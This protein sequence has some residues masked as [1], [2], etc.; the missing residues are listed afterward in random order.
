MTDLNRLGKRGS[1]RL[2]RLR[3]QGVG[4]LAP[5]LE[6]RPSFTQSRRR[7]SLAL[8][9]AGWVMLTALLAAGAALGMWFLPYAAGVVAGFVT[10]CGGWR[11]RPSLLAVIGT[12]LAGWGVPLGW[13]LAGFT[14]HSGAQPASTSAR[15]ITELTGRPAPA[16]MIFAGSLFVAVIQA[17]VGAW[18][19]RVL[20]PS[21]AASPLWAT[22][23]D[24]AEQ[25]TFA[26][27]TPPA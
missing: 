9:L 3:A 15:A 22:P 27:G 25:V 24:P 18:L 21:P 5:P 7:G 6:S 19:G 16:A 2:G 23:P 1:Y 14:A 12:A 26:P 11:L 13:S 10:G 17:L 8:W 4:Q 20:A